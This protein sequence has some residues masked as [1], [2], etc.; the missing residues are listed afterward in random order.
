MTTRMM[1]AAVGCLL[2]WQTIAGAADT[3]S[4]TAVVRGRVVDG[5]TG[6]PVG[7][8][9]IEL[10]IAGTMRSA[11]ASPQ[12]VF[13]FRAVPEGLGSLR[14][15]KSGYKAAWYPA[16]VRKPVKLRL[17]EVHRDQI[18]NVVVTMYRKPAIAGAVFD[19]YGDPVENVQVRAWRG[20]P[21]GGYLTVRG[22]VSTNDIGEFRLNNLE[23]GR[24][25]IAALPTWLGFRDADR[26]VPFLGSPFIPASR[27][28]IRRSRSMSR[29][30]RRPTT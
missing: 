18:E 27:H 30:E 24:Y 2:A 10:E 14:A 7:R 15:E 25:V 20:S 11:L 22:S 4:D 9:R 26:E 6:R 23:A 13:E 5:T 28:S 29:Q 21:F 19:E 17:L 16:R 3:Q 1:I 8:A 12:G